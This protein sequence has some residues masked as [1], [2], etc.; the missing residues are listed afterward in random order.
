MKIQS[1]VSEL[2]PSDT[3]VIN[4]ISQQLEKQGRTI[5]KFG[6]G[7]SPFPVPSIVR[8]AL[9]Q[10]AHQKDYLPVQGLQPLREK[11]AVHINGLLDHELYAA[12]NIFVGPGSKELIYLTQLAIDAPL[13]L[14]NPSWV[15]YAP[16]AKIVEK[17]IYWIPTR[18]NQW[19]LEADE[20]RFFLDQHDIQEGILLLNYPNNPTGQSFTS[21]ELQALATICREY[22]IIVISD[23]I[24]GSL[25]F[26][27][28]YKSIATYYPEGTII[29]TGLSKWAGAG[30]WRLG[31]M[32]IPNE[33]KI[34][35]QALRALASE[36]FSAVSAPV[37]YAAI[38]A[39]EDHPELKEYLHTSKDILKV[40]GDFCY[41]Q[42]KLGGV[43][44]T[45]AK[46]G[47]YLF[48]NFS[49]LIRQSDAIGFCQRVLRETGVAL[50]PG[51]SF[52][53]PVE[54]LT[55]R[56]CFVDFDG[57]KALDHVKSHGGIKQEH[58][59]LL[60]PR[61]IQGME[62]LMDWIRNHS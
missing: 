9:I 1:R 5:Y 12:D 41:Q 20:L 46:G 39:Y 48:P 60:F 59:P 37:Q 44:V 22:K 6:F 47:F 52:G 13:L 26:D 55:T 35:S 31:A 18:T 2:K 23:E 27:S 21:D 36:T 25:N 38:T 19:K 56:L 57:S 4:Q 15:S 8:E 10:N 42:L 54:E 62:E 51:T 33:L 45:P 7:Q 3:L 61:M 49:K 53:R 11:I 43:A 32:V 28:P 30:G 16:Q 50:L 40:I 17:K 34:L 58:L 29:T 24:Y 14:P